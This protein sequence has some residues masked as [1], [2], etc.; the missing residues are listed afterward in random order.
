MKMGKWSRLLTAG[1]L[2]ALLLTATACSEEELKAADVYSKS[3]EAMKKIDSFSANM[4]LKEHVEQGETN[5]DVNADIAMDTVLKPDQRFKMTMKMDAM[6][7]SVNIEA[8]LTKDGLFMKNP[9]N[10][11]WMKLQSDQL[12]QVLGGM[13][14]EQFDPAKQIKQLKPFAG[15]LTLKET[16][17]DYILKLNTSGDKMKDLILEQMKSQAGGSALSEEVVQSIDTMKIN[18]VF[19]EFTVDKKTY[20]LSSIKVN[21]D[22]EVE[23]QGEKVH[24]VIDMDGDY[25][26]FNNID[27]IKVPDE[28]ANAQ[29]VNI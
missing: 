24:M 1:M 4:T 8:Y 29:S 23:A 18:K 10:G 28:A 3:T 13:S 16:D 14:T 25:L 27:D 12:N 17:D 26:K 22:F 21:M 19:Y 6:G 2:V 15:D 9:V 20:Y 11:E 5:A 7:Q